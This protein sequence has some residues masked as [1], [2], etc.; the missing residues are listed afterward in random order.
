MAGRYVVLQFD[1]KAL[2]EAFL[3]QDR[4]LEHD[5][6][7]VIAVYLKPSQ[8]C[9]CPDKTRVNL[10]NWRKHRK[11]GLYV[12]TR[13]GRPSQFHNRGILERLQYAFGYDIRG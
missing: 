10:K 5:G 11:Y 1:D 2:A 13:C 9:E 8:F 6:A 3:A 12:C 7:E 4:A